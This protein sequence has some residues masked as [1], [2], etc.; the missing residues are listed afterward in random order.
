MLIINTHN[1]KLAAARV[2]FVLREMLEGTCL[3]EALNSLR[4]DTSEESSSDT[5]GLNADPDGRNDHNT[6]N[7]CGPVD[8]PPILG[9]VTLCSKKGISEW[10]VLNLH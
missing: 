10:S 2:D 9:E 7:S 8:G 3:G 4:D 1:D 6:D 5:P